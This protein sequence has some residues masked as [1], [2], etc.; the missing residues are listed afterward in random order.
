MTETEAWTHFNN[1]VRDKTEGEYGEF[2]NADWQA[3]CS[4]NRAIETIRRAAAA[5]EK[6]KERR[7][8]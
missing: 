7:G 8:E 5:A 3:A 1:R 6:N 2:T 4:L